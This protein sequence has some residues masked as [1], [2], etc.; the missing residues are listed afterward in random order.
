MV[1]VNWEVD[2]EYRVTRMRPGT[3]FTNADILIAQRR[4]QVELPEERRC[5][6]GLMRRLENAGLIEKAYPVQTPARSHGGIT[7]LWKRKQRPGED[8]GVTT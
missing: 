4:D 8:D 6:G 2:A 3:M 1:A 7:T 5:Y